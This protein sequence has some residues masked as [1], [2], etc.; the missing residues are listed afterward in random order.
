ML[1][2][3]PILCA[4]TIVCQLDKVYGKPQDENHARQILNELQGGRHLV[5]TAVAVAVPGEEGNASLL[6]LNTSEVTLAQ[7]SSQEIDSYIQSK[8]PFGKAGAYGIQGK[9]AAYIS[10]INGSY[11]GIMGLPLYETMQLLR[12]VGI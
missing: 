10:H 12:L 9:M 7:M 6:R 11:S 4:D 5:M 2:Q 1:P 8:E 3:A